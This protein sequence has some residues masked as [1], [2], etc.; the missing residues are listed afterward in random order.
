MLYHKTDEDTARKN[1]TVSFI[2]ELMLWI[3][4]ILYP[5]KIE[6]NQ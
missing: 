4:L 3:V 1:Y 5:S 2:L 6:N